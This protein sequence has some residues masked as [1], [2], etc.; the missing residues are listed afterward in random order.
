MFVEAKPGYAYTTLPRPRFIIR[1]GRMVRPLSHYHI[2]AEL[3]RGGM[4]VVYR[5]RTRASGVRSRSRCSP[6]RPRP[7]RTASA[8]SF[9]KRAGI[10][11]QPPQHRHHLRHRGSGR[12]HVHRD[13]ARE[14]THARSCGPAASY[15]WPSPSI[16]ARRS[17][18]R[19]RPRTQAA[20]SI[21]TSSRPTSRHPGRT[22][23]AARLR[24]G[25]ALRTPSKSGHDDGIRPTRR[26]PGGAQHGLASGS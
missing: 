5:A 18:R 8:G 14:G 26:I 16:S 13:G 25:Q 12:L 1:C 21:A 24:A 22:R 10:G 7:T 2:D 11:A 17:R 6:R 20:S 23:Q 4:G 9:K 19:S 15:R 3:G